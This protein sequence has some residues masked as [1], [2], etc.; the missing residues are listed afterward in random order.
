MITSGGDDKSL[1]TDD[2]TQYFSDLETESFG[3]DSSVSDGLPM[4]L[5][6]ASI[7]EVK[8]YTLHT[9]YDDF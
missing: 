9:I 1:I 5:L 3:S 6:H 7:P 2:H 4:Q 8:F